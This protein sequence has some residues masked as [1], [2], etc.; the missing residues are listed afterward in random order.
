[1]ANSKELAARRALLL[2]GLWAIAALACNLPVLAKDQTPLPPEPTSTEIPPYNCDNKLYPDPSDPTKIM[3]SEFSIIRPQ[4]GNGCG[5]V[6]YFDKEQKTPIVLNQIGEMFS[7]VAIQPVGII[8][9]TPHV[10]PL[11]NIKP[12]I[13]LYPQRD[14]EVGITIDGNLYHVTTQVKPPP[15]PINLHPRATPPGS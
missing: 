3:I 14:L 8:D 2:L 15:T 6:I 5:F 7:L 10:V 9:I 11:S 1:M 12:E 13:L 4:P